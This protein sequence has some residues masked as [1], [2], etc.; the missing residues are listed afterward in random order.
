LN[1]QAAG[2]DHFTDDEGRFYEAAA[3][4]L[5]KYGITFGCRADRFCGDEPIPRGQMAAFLARAYELPNASGDRFTDDSKSQ[6]EGAINKIA[7][8]GITLGCNPP[9]NDRFCPGDHVTRG[10]MA[11]FLKRAAE[12]D[13]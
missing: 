1:L 4:Q 2:S 12:W 3:N 10:Q 13:S 9:T 11:A 5:Y 6:F 7:S 8:A